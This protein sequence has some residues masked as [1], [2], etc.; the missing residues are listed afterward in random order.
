VNTAAVIAIV[1]GAVIVIALIAALVI[2]RKRRR[3]RLYDRFGP[4]YNRVLDLTD[5]RRKAETELTERAERRDQLDIRPLS[6]AAL[7]R[8]QE[9]WLHAQTEFVDRPDQAV[10]EADS[11]V[12]EVMAERGYPVDDFETRADLVSVDHPDLVENYRA[13][14]A[15]A[16]RNDRNEAS[17]E[18][19]RD[20]FLRYRALFEELLGTPVDPDSRAVS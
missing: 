1:V 9:R 6:H 11:L 5:S 14:H 16:V 4:E 2:M 10:R 8:F 3:A 20:A 18:E 13:G 19:L 7:V 17:V 15:I 12:G